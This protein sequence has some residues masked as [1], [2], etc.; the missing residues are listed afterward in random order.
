M[1]A[2]IRCEKCGRVFP[3]YGESL[4][5]RC[6]NEYLCGA[7]ITV[8]KSNTIDID[9]DVEKMK[10]LEIKLLH[11]GKP[12]AE[13]MMAGFVF[14]NVFNN[15]SFL[16]AR[17]FS[18]DGLNS[19]TVSLNPRFLSISKGMVDRCITSVRYQ[20][21][22]DGTYTDSGLYA[23]SQEVKDILNNQLFRGDADAV[24]NGDTAETT[25]FDGDS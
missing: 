5:L 20:T 2:I 22:R 14:V 19:I 17:I 12:Q 8:S 21:A 11:T 7:V 9:Y 16:A 4:T 15:N 6:K 1:F 23:L 3:Y 18:D 24:E 13:L 25:D 10:L